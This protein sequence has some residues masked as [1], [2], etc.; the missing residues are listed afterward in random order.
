MS[1]KIQ[2][3]TE[4]FDVSQK[5]EG[6]QATGLA[7]PFGVES[8]NGAMYDKESVKENA[9]S[10]K[11]KSV[12]YNHNPDR[13]PLGRVEKVQY[14]KDGLEYKIDFDEEEEEIIRKIE[15]GYLNNVSIQALVDEEKSEDE[16]WVE[17][18]MELTVTPLP[19]FPETT[20]DSES[21]SV[22]TFVEEYMDGEAPDEADEDDSEEEGKSTS[23]EPFGP[24]DDLGDCVD[25]MMANQDYDEET[26]KKVCGALQDELEGFECDYND[27]D[28]KMTDAKDDENESEAEAVEVGQ[29]D[30]QNLF[31]LVADMAPE[32]VEV[33]DVTSTMEDL[34]EQEQDDDDEDDEDEPEDDDDEEEAVE[35]DGDEEE[36]EEPEED[37]ET[38]EE[39][40]ESVEEENPEDESDSTEEEDDESEEESVDDGESKQVVEPEDSESESTLRDTLTEV[41]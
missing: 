27:G 35:D 16:L 15:N 32:G 14:T 39:E 20:L 38:D 33:A 19:G 22:T 28:D 34:F 17:E 41:L 9:D 24:W 26:A 30:L 23:K 13:P 25:D 8:R 21:M 5:E 18:F 36:E 6:V 10:L 31:A 40:E 4:S 12:L 3:R 11:G 7:L 2:L 29:V 1:K 37:E